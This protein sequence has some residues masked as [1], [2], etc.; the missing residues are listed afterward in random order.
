MLDHAEVVGLEEQLTVPARHRPELVDLW[1]SV[2]WN[3]PD[4]GWSAAFQTLALE[5]AA[6]LS[7]SGFFQIVSLS[8]RQGFI[9]ARCTNAKFIQPRDVESLV[10][11]L[12]RRTNATMARAPLADEASQPAES[13]S[14]RI[15]STF[16]AIGGLFFGLQSNKGSSDADVASS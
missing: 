2:R 13:R 3:A 7:P 6:S 9:V 12:V 15:R 10:R 1:I 14:D 8:E 5:E 11:G 4:Q 16:G